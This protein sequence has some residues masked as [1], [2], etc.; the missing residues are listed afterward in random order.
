M[1]IQNLENFQNYFFRHSVILGEHTKNQSVDCNI[2][3]DNNGNE[4]ERV[5]AGP[6]EIYGIESL[7]IHQDYDQP[8]Y[9]H[10]IG[11]IR[12][13]RDVTMKGIDIREVIVNHDVYPLNYL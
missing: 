11:L 10:D 3:R 6:I 7:K 5:C 2:F 12:L 13:D 9:A 8:R 4:L 1:I